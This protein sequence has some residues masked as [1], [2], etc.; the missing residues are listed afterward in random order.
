MEA[1]L[2]KKRILELYLNVI[3]FG[4]GVYGVGA[5]AE[6]FYGKE[7]EELSRAQMAMLVA[8]MPNPKGWSVRDPSP[9]VLQRQQRVLRLADRASFPSKELE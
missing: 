4:E 2:P 7:L 8:V 6:T 5:A 1:I 3:E 9:R